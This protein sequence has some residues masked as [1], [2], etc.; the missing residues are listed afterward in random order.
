MHIS[1]NVRMNTPAYGPDQVTPGLGPAPD[2]SE[3][4]EAKALAMLDVDDAIPFLLEHGLVQRDW[5]VKGDLILRSAARRNRNL[6]IEG[7]GGAGYLIKQP[8]DSRQRA[9]ARSPARLRFMSFASKRRPPR[10][11]P[12]CC[13]AWSC[14]TRIARCTPWN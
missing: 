5:I 14:A 2:G 8:D 4:T 10:L 13:L 6:R 12:A 1:S 9:A 11:W 7:P 3:A